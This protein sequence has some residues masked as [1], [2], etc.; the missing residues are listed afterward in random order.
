MFKVKRD[1]RAAAERVVEV[2]LSEVPAGVEIRGTTMGVGAAA[3]TAAG[4]NLI[5][6]LTAAGLRLVP[7]IRSDM[8]IPV[9][10][11]GKIKLV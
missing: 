9:D 11:Y 1:L 7:Y 6:E 10:E 4:T 3:G 8:G 2:F 5:A